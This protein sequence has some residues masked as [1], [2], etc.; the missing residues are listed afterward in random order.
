MKGT[1]AMRL[2]SLVGCIISTGRDGPEKV[3]KED[4][5]T[6]QSTDMVAESVWQEAK[7]R[8]KLC[9]ALS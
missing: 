1:L 3:P 7:F 2:D 5:Q 9:I 4:C 6:N 8:K